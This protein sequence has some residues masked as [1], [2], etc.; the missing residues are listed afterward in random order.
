[1]QRDVYVHL[2][3]HK[4]ASTTLQQ[5]LELNKEYL[6]EK[7]FWYITPSEIAKSPLGRHFRGI[8]QNKFNTE[9]FYLDSV[10]HAKK[11]AEN[12]IK[13]APDE[14]LKIIFSW[15]GFLGHSALD[16]YQGIYTTIDLV[17]RSAAEIFGSHNARFLIVIR[18]QD[19]FIESCYLQQIKEKRA[20]SFNN[21]VTN[22]APAKM[23]WLSILDSV[24][25]VCGKENI[26]VVPFELIRDLGTR[27]FVTECLERLT[28][29]IGVAT[30]FTW[31]EKANP[32]ISG[33]GVDIALQTLPLLD[34]E[35]VK[36]D[37]VRFVFSNL[38]SS[39]HGKPRYLDD[40]ARRLLLTNCRNDN[41]AVFKEYMSCYLDDL[42]E[43]NENIFRYYM[44]SV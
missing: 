43:R 24:A 26:S 20:L 22:L 12:L 27:G 30:D 4:S 37:F 10:S 8:S 23:S 29:E 14:K 42:N 39:K 25:K 17:A 34:N 40:F 9:D 38:S 13:S 41:A 35:D 28:S 3:A 1:M 36:K 15:E 16:Y 33:V 44:N 5:N 2:G 11:S 6:K 31:K 32:S 19:D 21:F 18:R 7:G